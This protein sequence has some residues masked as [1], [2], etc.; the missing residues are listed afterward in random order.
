[1]ASAETGPVLI[2]G[3]TNLPGLSE[4]LTANLS[5]F[6]DG[7]REAGA[8]FGYT[9]PVGHPWMRIDRMFTTKELAFTSFSV[10]CRWTSDH[11]CISAE[12]KR[13]N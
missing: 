7:F 13:A 11:L 6:S 10:G 12:V 2:A 9:F 4:T 3:D 1:M 5:N 8:G